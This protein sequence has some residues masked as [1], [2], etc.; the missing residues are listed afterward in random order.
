MAHVN[1]DR[2]AVIAGRTYVITGATSGLGRGT[3]LALAEHGAKVVVAGR[4]RDLLEEV[5]G[6]AHTAGGQAV[7]VE[8]DVSRA[9]DVEAIAAAAVEHFGGIDAW[10][11]NAGIGALGRFW[12]IPLEDHVR[13]IDVNLK[14]VIFGSHVALRGFIAQGHGTLVNIGSIDS[15]VPLAYQGSYSASKAGVLSLGRALNEELRLAGAERIRVSTVMPWAVDTPWWEHAANYS[16]GT[17]RMAAM[18]DPAMVVEKIVEAILDPREEV[19]VGWKA[20]ASAGTHVVA[21]DLAERFSAGVAHKWQMKD[22]PPAPPTTGTLYE[23]MASGRNVEGG[24]RDRM[25]REKSGD[26]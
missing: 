19:V 8:A 22:A 16:G 4:R 2:R 20:K 12:D 11:N 15:E 13:V 5:V 3:A 18:D 14:G 24:V 25:A 17:P 26:G 6:Q 1:A 21:A 7:P 10:V 23:P 9:E